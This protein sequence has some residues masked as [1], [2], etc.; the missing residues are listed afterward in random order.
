M[1][2]THNKLVGFKIYS[3]QKAIEKSLEIT[4]RPF[5]LTPGQWNLLNQLD[6]AGNL[7]QKALAIRTQKEQATI[8]RYLDS[9]E[10]KGFISRERDVNDRRAHIVS[11]T[12]KARELLKKVE[13]A[14]Q[15]R[16]KNLVE[17]I[18]EEELQAFLKTL[19]TLKAN[20]EK[21]SEY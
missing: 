2:N 10:R 9:L 19:E 4:L 14:T 21:I 7:T 6:R 12:D 8:T 15:D 16:Q 20:A 3:A 17:N 1:V 13:P 11:I 18:S 5:G